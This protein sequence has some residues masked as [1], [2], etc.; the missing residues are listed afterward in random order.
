MRASTKKLLMYGGAA[1]AAYYFFL[2]PKPM[3][4]IAAPAVAG[5][6]AGFGYFPSGS[7]RPFARVYG[8]HP[9]AWA[10]THSW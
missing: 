2:K 6:V 10:K 5:P 4:M 1:C 9:T 3:P 7:D 8:G